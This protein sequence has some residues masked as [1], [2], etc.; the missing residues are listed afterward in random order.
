M[1]NFLLESDPDNFLVDVRIAPG[2]HIE[3]FIDNDN[4]ITIEKCVAVNRGLYKKIE[5]ELFPDG[6]F[7]LE[8][9]SPGLEEPLKLHRQFKKNLGRFVEVTLHDGTCTEGKLISASDNS[10]EIEEAKGKKK[11]P[12]KHTLLFEHIKTT[13]IKVVF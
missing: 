13:K 3:V 5:E 12:V 4:G 11:E 6:N 10:I 1:V 9:S 7:S 8:V 2:N